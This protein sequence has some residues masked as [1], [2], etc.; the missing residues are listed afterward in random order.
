MLRKKTNFQSFQSSK[1][2]RMIPLYF[3]MFDSEAWQ[4]L[5][6][7]AIK[8]YL[9]MLRKYAAKYVKGELLR[10][11]K[12]NISMPRSEYLKFMAKNTFEKCV[13]ELIDYGFIRIVEYKP[14]A[15]SRKVIIY[16][17]NDMWKK[18]GTD[19]FHVK[20]EWKRAKHRSYI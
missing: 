20:E 1:G 2:G 10:C 5:S 12:D 4:S 13:D 7:N 11:N 14:M 15:G 16:G 6:A 9:H 19:K 8:L 18:Y 17:F 3:D